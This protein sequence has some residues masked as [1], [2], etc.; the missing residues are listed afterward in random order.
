MIYTYLVGYGYVEDAMNTTAIFNVNTDEKDPKKAVEEFVTVIRTAASDKEIQT[1]LYEYFNY[2]AD[3]IGSIG[4]F[5]DIIGVDWWGTV[6]D[7]PIIE[8]QGFNH[9]FHAEDVGS[10]DLL[11]CHFD[12]IGTGTCERESISTVDIWK[13]TIGKDTVEEEEEPSEGE[14]SEGDRMFPDS[15]DMLY[16]METEGS[17][18][19]IT[20]MTL[21]AYNRGNGMKIH[22][23]KTFMV[24]TDPHNIAL[25]IKRNVAKSSTMVTTLEA[26]N[27]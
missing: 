23:D 1:F 4:S 2:T 13:N 7:G 24:G 19:K 6:C 27:G 16:Q 26:D 14:P 3:E 25:W 22:L 21:K 20:L 5:E 18:I 15:M 11:R 12:I 8:L 9:F 10:S 17:R